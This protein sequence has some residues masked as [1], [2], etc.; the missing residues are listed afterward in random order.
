MTRFLLS[1]A[2]LALPG[3]AFAQEEPGAPAVEERP[4]AA[5]D[6]SDLSKDELFAR[7]AAAD[8]EGPQ[9]KRLEQEI[10]RRFHRSGSETVDLLF[11]RALEAMN[12]QETALTLDLLDEVI[13]LRPDFAEAWNKRATV[14]YLARDYGRS[15][16]DIRETLA[17]E[18]RHFG[19][20]AGLGMILET[21]DRKEE[22][23]RAL[24]RALDLNPQLDSVR[25]SAESLEKELSG[26]AI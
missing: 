21:L 12:A 13:L 7:L 6:I 23:L 2:L 16:A 20:L 1:I 8:G 25:E 26:R 3:L 9:A 22:A 11:A 17:L 18:P 4:L 15:L 10:L 19:A 24:H 5:S 14:H